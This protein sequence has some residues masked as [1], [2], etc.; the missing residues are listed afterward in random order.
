MTL[1]KFK[2]RH[3]AKDLI[4]IFAIL[5]ITLLSLTVK[6]Q[7]HRDTIKFDTSEVITLSNNLISI[8]RII[9]KFDMSSLLRDKVDS[10]LNAEQNV[11][12][13]RFKEA[14][15]IPKQKTTK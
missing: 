7:R 3:L 14:A 12:F 5:A 4:T 9:H 10:V 11:L 15:I 13:R 1:H 2:T 6:A 8:Q